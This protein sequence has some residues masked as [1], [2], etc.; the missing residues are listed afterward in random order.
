MIRWSNF[1]THTNTRERIIT[2]NGTTAV[3]PAWE[4]GFPP[5]FTS[6]AKLND[7]ASFR[8]TVVSEGNELMFSKI[9]VEPLPEDSLNVSGFCSRSISDSEIL[10]SDVFG[11]SHR[12]SQ[13]YFMDSKQSFRFIEEIVIENGPTTFR[14][15]EA[16]G[17]GGN[18]F[19]GEWWEEEGMTGDIRNAFKQGRWKAGVVK[20][21]NDNEE[22]FLIPSRK[23]FQKRNKEEKE[24]MQ[25]KEE[26]P[27]MTIEERLE[28]RER[29]LEYN[30]IR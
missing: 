19:G 2:P 22:D 16:E 24:T 28:Q 30:F 7:E 9:Q 6:L 1:K 27:K 11:Q 17:Q 5:H 12:G 18:V 20:D 29:D 13:Y 15:Y 10:E 26:T 8:K 21:T 3:T 23:P 4:M 25:E 14:F